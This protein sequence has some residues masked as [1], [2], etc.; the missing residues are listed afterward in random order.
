M[1]VG[2][3]AVQGLYAVRSSAVV[4][5]EVQMNRAVHCPAVVLSAPIY[6][7]TLKF[8]ILMNL[9]KRSLNTKRP[10]YLATFKLFVRS[11]LDLGTLI[12]WRASA[13]EIGLHGLKPLV[14]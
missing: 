12:S 4:E 11:S 8:F 3:V 2:E 1:F 5:F 6:R 7:E 10:N 14:T 9:A 13:C